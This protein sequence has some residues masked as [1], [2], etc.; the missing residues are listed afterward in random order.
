MVDFDVDLL[1][2]WPMF[3]RSFAYALRY[4]WQSMFVGS[5]DGP[6]ELCCRGR[7]EEN[8]QKEK[9]ENFAMQMT[10]VSY[11]QIFLCFFFHS[12]ISID[13]SS[14]CDGIRFVLMVEKG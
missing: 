2:I 11:L 8:R 12:T 10:Y 1:L 6:A 7:T 4:D 13:V 14:V 9:N 5:T 3:V